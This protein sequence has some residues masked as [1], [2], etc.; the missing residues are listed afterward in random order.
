MWWQ[1]CASKFP[2]I[3]KV[4]K[5]FLAI[6]AT[7]ISSERTFSVAGLTV[8]SLRSSLDPDTVDKIVFVN[9]NLKPSIKAFIESNFQ[10]SGPNDKTEPTT[11]NGLIPEDVEL[12]V[13][14]EI[15]VKDL[16]TEV[17]TE[18]FK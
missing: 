16:P 3:A 7:S 6:P 4:A 10:I 2:R 18:I 17:K 5:V 1:L 11:E 14:G 13:S 9:K 15:N 8:N 12:E